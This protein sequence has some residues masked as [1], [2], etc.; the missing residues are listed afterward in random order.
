MSLLKKFSIL[1]YQV[2]LI[3]GTAISK[4]KLPGLISDSMVL[5]HDASLKIWGWARPGE[6]VE[7]IFN[8]KKVKEGLPASPS[9]L[10]WK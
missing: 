1:L 3:V 10:N 2:S 5:Q 8:T 9:Q 7:I 4:V 6:Q